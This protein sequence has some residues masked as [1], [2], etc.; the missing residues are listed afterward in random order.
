M[1]QLYW[2]VAAVLLVGYG[3]KSSQAFVKAKKMPLDQLLSEM[4]A[5]HHD[6]HF[7]SAKAKMKLESDDMR[8]T[9][10][11]TIH[12][13]PDSLIWMNFK[14]IG[15][16]GGR[17]LIRQDSFWILYRLEDA[18]ETG[19]Y[20]ELMD[21]Y[22]LH[23]TFSELQDLIVGNLPIPTEPEV[24]DFRTKDL[25]KLYFRKDKYRYDYEIDGET[26]IR[27][28]DWRDDMYRSVDGT[29]SGYD[30]TGF[31]RDKSVY[32]RL[33]DGSSGR[34]QMSF[35]SVRFDKPKEI[36]FEVPADYIRLP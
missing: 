4:S 15:I 31:A 21:A 26:H 34:I 36:K 30:D 6:Y 17:A 7:F 11:A 27:G 29:M 9:G 22:D 16:E 2:Y 8:M 33:D 25:H 13:I 19:T 5:Q 20:Q 3:C 1:R 28:F 32:A 23:L 12:M 10:R 35:I 18:Y 24:I 14:K